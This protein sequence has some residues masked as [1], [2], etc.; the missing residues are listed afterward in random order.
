MD[1][2][3][4]ELAKDITLPA[5]LH[6]DEAFFESR[7]KPIMY[8]YIRGIRYFRRNAAIAMGNIGDP[9]FIPELEM[10]LDN[11]DEM[12]RDA[13]EWALKKIREKNI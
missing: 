5:L 11:S 2:Y 8:N 4:A 9:A 13:V 1:T 6:M 10:E 3:T 7:I 12:I